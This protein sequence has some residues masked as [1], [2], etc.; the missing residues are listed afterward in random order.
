MRFKK[1]AT[2]LLGMVVFPLCMTS[3]AQASSDQRLRVAVID[4][5]LN[6]HDPR[7]ADVLCPNGHRDLTGEGLQD[8][9][10]HGTHV[11]GIL[12]MAA[13][14]HTIYKVF[15]RN[16][17]QYLDAAIQLLNNDHIKIAN[18]SAS[19]TVYD[20]M[21]KQY[22]AATKAILVVA[23]GNNNTYYKEAY[24]GGYGLHNVFAVGN[25]DCAHSRRGPASNYGEGVVW[26]CGTNIISTLPGGK[27]GARTGT[28]QAAP[29][30]TAELV[31]KAI[32]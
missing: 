25:W 12:A 7:F 30:Y 20:L 1:K 9:N 28:S 21:E 22:A 19:G 27:Y 31:E 14:D 3:F 32:K 26:R 24:P 29:L 23:A 18:I 13:P 10:G 17:N 5:G 15:S 11:A 4:T 16:G 6:I 8:E 2:R